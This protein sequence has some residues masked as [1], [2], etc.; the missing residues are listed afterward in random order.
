MITKL[1][2]FNEDLVD[3]AEND[4]Q[5]VNQIEGL[6]GQVENLKGVIGQMNLMLLKQQKEIK[7]LTD[8][9]EKSDLST[10]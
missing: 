3:E 7:D 5:Q 8:T 10:F 4:E 9:I 2:K 6:R 1:E